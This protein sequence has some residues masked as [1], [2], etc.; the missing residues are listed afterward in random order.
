MQQ[1]KTIEGKLQAEGLRFALIASRFNDFIVSRLIDGAVDFLTRHGADKDNLTL[2][3]VPGSFE[4]SKTARFLAD[5]KKYDGIICLGAIIRGAT[6][7]FD[8]L[9][10]ETMK[11][12]A[13]IDLEH[14]TPIGFGIITA[15][16]LEQA[17][18]RAGTKAGNKGAEAASACLEMVQVM[19]QIV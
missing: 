4:I 3:R 19:R 7:H 8:L 15:D 10:N 18:E 1:I 13:K 14:N 6:T 5:S 2:I 12:L 9:A 17:I 11:G 16:T